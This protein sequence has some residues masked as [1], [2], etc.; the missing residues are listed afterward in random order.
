MKKYLVRC[1]M[2]GAS[3]IVSYEQAEPGKSEY[4]VGQKMFMNDLSALLTGLNAGSYEDIDILIYDEHFYG[5]NIDLAALPANA[6]AICGKPPYRADWAGGLDASYDGLILLGFHSKFGSGELLHHSY[7][8]DIK[9]IRIND[10]SVGEIGV[11]TAIAGDYGVALQLICADSA[12]VAEALALAPAARGIAVKQSLSAGGGLCL[13]AS[14]SARLIREAATA[15]VKHGSL[16]RPWRV[17]DPE[18][19]IVLNPGGYQDC[20]NELFQCR[21]TVKLRGA[22]VTECWA[23]YWHMKLEAQAQLAKR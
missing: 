17:K 7:E 21:G 14:E 6:R 9:D 11:E 16:A 18:M 8:L 1:D 20:F 19:S 12:G 22:T 13:P 23:T 5:R 2:E 15:L 10:R 3:G 4:A